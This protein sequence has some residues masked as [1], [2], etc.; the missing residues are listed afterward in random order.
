MC[1]PTSES[2]VGGTSASL[3]RDMKVILPS[4]DCYSKKLSKVGLHLGLTPVHMDE[5]VHLENY[6]AKATCNILPV[7]GWL[8]L[9]ASVN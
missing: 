7:L 3:R 1:S 4:K 5:I 9:T 6:M 2:L 8:F